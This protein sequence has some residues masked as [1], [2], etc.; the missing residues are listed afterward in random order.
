MVVKLSK[1]DWENCS[2]KFYPQ[3]RRIFGVKRNYSGGNMNAANEKRIFQVF[4]KGEI[5]LKII[6]LEIDEGGYF[7]HIMPIEK[8]ENAAEVMEHIHGKT[9]VESFTGITPDEALKQCKKWIREN[10]WEE[11]QAVVEPKL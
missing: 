6:I 11:F 1:K 5:Y 7:S 3:Y 10:L 2:E 9:F 8:G 4:H